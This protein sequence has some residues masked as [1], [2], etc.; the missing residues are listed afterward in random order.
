M[1]RVSKTLTEADACASAEAEWGVA[2]TVWPTTCFDN[3]IRVMPR[4]YF[5]ISQTIFVSSEAQMR[6]SMGLMTQAP[7]LSARCEPA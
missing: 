4:T 5:T 7:F 2:A 6:R 3:P 1:D